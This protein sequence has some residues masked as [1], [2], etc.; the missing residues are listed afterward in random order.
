MDRIIYFYLYLPFFFFLFVARSHSFLSHRCVNFVEDVFPPSDWTGLDALVIVLVV[1]VL[2]HTAPVPAEIIAYLAPFL[3]IHPHSLYSFC[4]NYIYSYVCRS[5][6]SISCT[7]SNGICV[8][9]GPLSFQR[10]LFQIYINS[11][12]TLSLGTLEY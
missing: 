1:A 9:N 8:S 2:C 10:S 12:S 11:T 3:F 4:M 5:R 6:L 7:S